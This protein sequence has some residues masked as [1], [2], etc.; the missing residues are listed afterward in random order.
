LPYTMQFGSGTF[1]PIV[2]LTYAGHLGH[3]S[4]GGQTLNYIR[5]G[6]NDEGYRLG[7]KYTLSGWVAR[8]VLPFA[9]L[10]VGVEGEAWRNVH[11]RDQNLP[12]TAIAGSN[13]GEIA[14]ERVLG[15]IGLNVMP[16]AMHNSLSGHR[17]SVEFGLPLYERYS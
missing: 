3:W 15:L 1:D 16:G 11:G 2:G 5:L 14:G 6:T 12:L 13:P 7:N 9:S 10:S 8:E 17:L 4:W